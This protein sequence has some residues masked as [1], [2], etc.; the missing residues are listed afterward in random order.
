MK[1]LDPWA[2]ELE[3]TSL[4][5]ASAGTGKTYTLTTLWLRLL[6][7]HDLTPDEI[8]V[9]T[10][11][12]AATAELRERI[13]ERLQA[14][15]AAVDEAVSGRVEE[16][17]A[18]GSDEANL[19]RL[20]APARRRPGAPTRCARRS[21]ASMKRRS[22]RSTDSVSERCRRTPSRVDCPSTPSWSN[23][24]SRSS[25]PSFTTSFVV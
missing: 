23:A 8:L 5:E 2:V 6:V 11:T 1:A 25:G 4:I 24:R 19:L 14:A 12:Q 3:G 15:I 22:S 17:P 13:R 21:G 9:V 20:A 18:A 16:A 7:E 10:Y